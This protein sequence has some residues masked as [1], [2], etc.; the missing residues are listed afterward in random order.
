MT[1]ALPGRPLPRRSLPRRRW[2]A[3]AAALVLAGCGFRLR[4]AP[5]LPF[6]SIHL[7]FAPR[8]E[9]G[10]EVRRQLAT[11]PGLRL[12]ETPQEAD[13]VLD[14][15]EDRM[16]RAVTA[17]TG[18][19]QVREFYVRA[20]LRF[21]LRT[22]A[23][24]ELI[25]ETALVQSQLLGYNESAALGKELEEAELVRDLRRDLAAQLLRR[26]AAVKP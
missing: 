20:Y 24:R 25:P 8:S 3:G 22:P 15:L 17:T 18:A 12:T 14:V 10:Q 19:G 9:L 26:L 13:V 6:R 7:G 2:L 16:S 1:R 21:R 4:G 11:L 23:G 5:E